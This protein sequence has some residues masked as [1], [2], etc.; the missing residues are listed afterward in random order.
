MSNRHHKPIRSS[1]SQGT[2]P[3]CTPLRV[4]LL[5]CELRSGTRSGTRDPGLEIPWNPDTVLVW[6]QITQIY[7]NGLNFFFCVTLSTV[8]SSRCVFPVFSPEIFQGKSISCKVKVFLVFTRS[9]KVLK[10]CTLLYVVSPSYRGIDRVFF[11]VGK[12]HDVLK[13]KTMDKYLE[14]TLK[15][16]INTKLPTCDDKG[17]FTDDRGTYRKRK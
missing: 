15:A 17:V 6:V 3:P 2:P 10:V 1:P 4:S 14:N 7:S 13:K 8:P 12:Q 9:P 16:S 5:R 11:S